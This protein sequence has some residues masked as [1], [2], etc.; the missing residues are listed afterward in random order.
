MNHKCKSLIKIRSSA[1]LPFGLL[2]GLGWIAPTHAQ[3]TPDR[4]LGDERSRVNSNASVRG[5]RADR[6]DGGASRG[7][8]LFHS[9]QEFNVGNGQRVYFSNPASITNI[10]SRVTGTNISRISGTLGVDGAANLFL[11]NPNGILFGADAR[12]DISGSFVATTANAVQFGD[13]GFFSA[14]LPEQS[15][16]LEIDPSALLFNQIA[17]QGGEI[18]NAGTLQTGQNLTLAGQNLTLQ[19]QIW[20]GNNLNLQAQ[21]TIRMRDS[22]TTPAI[23]AARGELTLQGNQAIDIFAL[24]HPQSGLFS[25]A[26]LTLR[27]ANPV[28]GDA[29]YWSG[30]NFRIEQLNG[31]LGN[32]VSPFDPVIRS[33]GDVS[34]NNY[35]GASLHIIAGGSVNL[36]TAIITEPEASL[37]RSG[38]LQETIQLSN[39]T[40]L[41]INGSTQATLDIRAGVAPE[42][43]F[44]AGLTGLTPG[45]DFFFDD[46]SQLNS[47]VLTARPTG[48]DIVIGDVFMIP[49]DGLVY[50]TNQYSPQA[51]LPSGTIT[52]TGRGLF[53]RGNVT[54]NGIDARGFGGDGSTVMLDARGDIVLST[55]FIDTSSDSGNA[56]QIALLAGRDIIL[57]SST[58][59]RNSD[60]KAIAEAGEGG[61]IALSAGRNMIFDSSTVEVSGARSGNLSLSA[62]NINLV[63]STLRAETTGSGDAQRPI[64]LNARGDIRLENSSIITRVDEQAEGNAAGIVIHTNDLTVTNSSTLDASTSGRGNAGDIEIHATG[65]VSFDRGEIFG[66]SRPSV[67]RS[68]VNSGAVGNG[69]NIFIRADSLYLVNGGRLEANVDAPTVFS[70]GEVTPAGQGQAGNIDVN[71]QNEVVISGQI[72]RVS[73]RQPS[74]SGSNA[75]VFP[76]SRSSGIF[77]VIDQEA[78]G[79]G[80]TVGLRARSLSLLDGGQIVASNYSQGN[81]GQINLDIREAIRLGGTDILRRVGENSE[82]IYLVTSAILSQIGQGASGNSG[83]VTIQ[84]SSLTMTD[85]SE[86]SA[87]TFG[88]GNAGNLSLQVDGDVALSNLSSIR[89]VVEPGA[90]GNGGNIGIQAESLSLTNGAQIVAGIFRATDSR[91]GGQGDGGRI[92][93]N[94]AESIHISGVSA[95]E[96]PFPAAN[97]LN[98]SSESPSIAVGARDRLQTAGIS[99]GILTIT[100]VGANG[101]ASDIVVNTDTLRIANGAVITA[102]TENRGNGGNILITANALD[103]LEGGQIITSTADTGRSGNIVL[104]V[105]DRIA[106]SGTDATYRD[107]LRDFGRG[108][109]ANVSENSGLFANTELGST[110]NGGTIAIRTSRLDLTDRA[111]VL[112]STSGTGSAGQISIQ[113]ASAV[114]LDNSAISTAVNAESVLAEP[115]N[116]SNIDLQT[117]SLSLRNRA[118]ITASTSGR[119]NAGSITVRDADQIS[120]SANSTISTTVNQGAIGQGGNITL[121]TNSLNLTDRS[122]ITS[123]TSGQGN[124]G[125]ID[126]QATDRIS[127][128]SNSDIT[129]TVNQGA[130]GDSQRITLQTPDL[131][132]RGD[133][134][135][136]AA[137]RGNGIAGDILIRGINGQAADRISI[138]NSRIS[139]EVRNNPNVSPGNGTVSDRNANVTR[140]NANRTDRNPTVS[141]NNPDRQGNITIVGRSIALDNGARI[142]ASTNGQNRAGDITIRQAETVSLT[143]RSTISTEVNSQGTGRGGSI[144][145]RTQDLELEGRSRISGRSSGQGRAGDIRLQIDGT[146]AADDSSIT[147]SATNAAGGAI[148][149]DGGDINLSNGSTIRTDV[150]RGLANGGNVTVTANNIRLRGDSDIQTRVAQGEGDGGDIAIQAD[151]VIA[152]DDS[153]II[154]NASNQGGDIVLDTPVFFGAGYQ[155]DA[156]GEGN[157]D[158]NDR[159]DLDAFGQVSSGAVQVP[160][161]NFIQNS[162]ADL[163]ENAVDTDRLIANSCIARTESGGTFLVTGSGGLPLRPG[164]APL[165]PYPTGEV[166]LGAAA[167][168]SAL[169]QA[170]EAIVEPQGVYQLPNGQLV[171]SREC[172]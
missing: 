146:L 84:A 150:E 3:I 66:G 77:S 36:G 12:L 160:N 116:Q 8:N 156:A 58:S 142:T 2:L 114:S 82:A 76:N 100:E 118:A 37:D 81:S 124:T 163:T 107:R 153:D 47:A 98:F 74:I 65:R 93:I 125:T 87:S 9:F 50:L 141:G 166:R 161:T 71:V 147:T 104:N 78:V 54:G 152:F 117:R 1:L 11:L 133:S 139:T 164:T 39:G 134:Q 149:I 130:T 158:G 44:P 145:I 43:V 53:R 88:L 49:P 35:Q 94:T 28:S 167:D 15:N 29:H 63:G 60:I 169:W 14:T 4:T 42:E 144:D 138:A 80:G 64:T 90:I 55:S 25:G 137:T 103:V 6:I 33:L 155:A 97:P 16:L 128:T 26:N 91:S 86:I 148:A 19:G 122:S 102:Q 172:D 10:F 40:R 136:S 111:Q 113:D 20:A 85:V 101:Q 23:A 27:S 99:S 62:E 75:G 72:D 21:D 171:M 135:I 154:S 126:I 68:N 61:A 57:S 140:D 131:A 70:N 34:F 129:S 17:A 18:I 46:A 52:I 121:S 119:G 110:G 59:A 170:G 162:L 159:V 24:N 41:A 108:T 165:S 143:D 92:D 120:L 115:N 13:R 7:S 83:G 69:G 45:T 32:L 56:G 109:I 96:L 67:A 22:S 48:A 79:N 89:S 123:S 38:Y 132:L 168:E 51:G 30:G 73:S 157:A 151:S 112:A 95:I 5:Q 31:E 105:R 127:L 106:L